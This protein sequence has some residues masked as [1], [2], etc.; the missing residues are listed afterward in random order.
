VVVTAPEPPSKPTKVPPFTFTVPPL[1]YKDPAVNVP[2]V[3][4]PVL[5][6]VPLLSDPLKVK[7]PAFVAVA[8]AKSVADAMAVE[9]MLSVPPLTADNELVPAFK[10]NEPDTTLAMLLLP[11]PLSVNDPPSSDPL[12]LRFPA[13]ATIPPVSP[14]VPVIDPLLRKFVVPV[15]LRLV[16]VTVPVLAEKV[17]V[18]AFASAPKLPLATLNNADPLVTFT[19]LPPWSALSTVS[20][21]SPTFNAPLKPDNVLL[22][23]SANVP[24]EVKEP[25]PANVPVKEPVSVPDTPAVKVPALAT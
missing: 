9:A 8:T 10:V 6:K 17:N 20:F 19:T 23:A 2:M 21:P 25:A 18:E 1:A 22:V 4:V 12:K 7:L 15:P 3:N 13:T 24:V 16:A 14:D 11:L 5:V